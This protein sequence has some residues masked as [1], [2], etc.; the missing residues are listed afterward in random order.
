MEARTL[1]IGQA[2]GRIA[3]GA[4]LLA[5]PKPAARGW[6]G[7]VAD[8]PGALVLSAGL[9]ARDVA[10]GAGVLLA[11][12]DGTGARQWLRGAVVADLADVTSSLRARGEMTTVAFAST[13]A[14]A[15]GSAALGAWLQ[16]QLD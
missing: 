2:V 15:G 8:E 9:G 7:A 5:A 16:T 10:L 1:A 12:R 14:L 4:A 6:L 3:I 11:L 13:V